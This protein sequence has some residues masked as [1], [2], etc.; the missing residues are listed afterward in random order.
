MRDEVVGKPSLRLGVA[1]AIERLKSL[2]DG[3]GAFSDVLGFGAA[4]VP[5]LR[6]RPE[7]IPSLIRALAEDELRLTAETVLRSF[8]RSAGPQLVRVAIHSVDP[9]QRESDLRR[10][11]SS[12]D[13]GILT[14]PIRTLR[15]AVAYGRT[16]SRVG[17]R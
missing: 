16:L 12:Q 9:I 11:T 13:S 10:F 5:Q 6:K 14:N 1:S 2:H 15:L 3:D 8:G 7:S 17:F 4:A